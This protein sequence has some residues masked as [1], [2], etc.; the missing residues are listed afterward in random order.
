[1]NLQA[2]TQNYAGVPR[3]HAGK[4]FRRI[5][6]EREHVR[7]TRGGIP[8]QEIKSFDTPFVSPIIHMLPRMLL[9]DSHRV[10]T[11]NSSDRHLHLLKLRQASVLHIPCVFHDAHSKMVIH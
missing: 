9:T 11:P 7:E 10:T 5:H 3:G 2:C 6:V 8:P 4:K 1:M